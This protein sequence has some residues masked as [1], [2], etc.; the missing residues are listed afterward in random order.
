M[1][2]ATKEQ[3]EYRLE[4]GLLGQWYVVGKS[5]QVQL[6]KPYGV[7]ALGR[8]LV[9]WRDVAGKLQCVEDYCPH[10]GAR[11]SR[12]EIHDG[13]IACRYHGVTLD[14]TG[15][16]LRVPA[17]PGCALEG[18]KAVDA[19]EVLEA[20]D[21]VFVF[22]PSAEKPKAPPLALP[23]EFSDS[24]WA[25]FLCMGKW[26]CSYLFVYDNFAD[27]MHACYLHADSF[28]LAFGAKQDVMKLEERPDGFYI[29]KV[30][31]QD[32][33]LDWTHMVMDGDQVYC[34]LDIPYPAAMGPGGPFRIIG[35]AT[36]I[37]ENS[38]MTFFWRFRQVQQ[39]AR[40][41]WRFLYR[42]T[43]EFRHWFVLEQ[44]REMLSHIPPDA[45]KREMLYQHD[46]GV[47]R[48]RRTMMRRAK[49]QIEAEETRNTRAA[50]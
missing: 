22:F 36:P 20:N 3:I 14:G 28:T 29:A 48:M 2:L 38:C 25:S 18:R 37:D 42:A 44:D 6:G 21:A 31:Q 8:H 33:N 24:S 41:S 32:V 5:V 26:D 35:Y 13:L 17:M 4:T 50:V 45:H 11:L 9:L 19:Y 40:E 12:G 49:A 10:R 15:T 47:S 1:N 30:A 46:V 34:R 39:T 27:P 7:K 16:V 43:Q 23:E